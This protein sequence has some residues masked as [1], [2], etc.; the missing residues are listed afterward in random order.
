MG[1]FA[2]LAATFAAYVVVMFTLASVPESG[3]QETAEAT[4]MTIIN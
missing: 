1:R 2:I 4:N 3:S